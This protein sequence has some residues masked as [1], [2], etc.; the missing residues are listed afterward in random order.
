MLPPSVSNRITGQVLI[1]WEEPTQPNGIILYYQVERSLNGSHEY[2]QL[3]NE[4]SLL[5]FGDATVEPYTGY[6]Y[7]IVAVNSAGSATGPT[8]TILTPEAG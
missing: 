6:S 5:V 4:S 2:I 1:T 8:S 7:R 3:S